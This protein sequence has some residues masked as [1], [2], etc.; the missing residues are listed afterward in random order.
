MTVKV[1]APGPAIGAIA[2]LTVCVVPVMTVT[3]AP[4]WEMTVPAA[5]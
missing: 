2:T 3:G 5:F 1:R 4:P